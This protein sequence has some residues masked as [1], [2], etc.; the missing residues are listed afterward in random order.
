MPKG[1]KVTTATSKNVKKLR[2]RGV[3]NTRQDPGYPFCA[4]FLS[5][6]YVYAYKPHYQ[7]QKMNL[8]IEF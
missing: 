3:K 6:Q 4:F 2:V 5:I 8:N 1:V 7:I